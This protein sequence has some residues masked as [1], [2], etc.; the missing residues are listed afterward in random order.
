[1]FWCG[2]KSSR[3]AVVEMTCGMCNFT[4]NRMFILKLWQKRRW[5]VLSFRKYVQVDKCVITTKNKQYAQGG[6]S[7]DHA[8][9][10][11]SGSSQ[12]MDTHWVTLQS[13]THK[14]HTSQSMDTHWVTLQRKTHKQHTSQSM[15]T[16]W[17]TLQRKTHKQHTS[18][19]MDTHW[20][21][22]QS[23]THK[24]HTS[25]S[26]DTH[27]VTLQSKTHKQHTSQSMDTHWVT[28]QSKT[29]KQ[30]TSQSMDTHWV[31]LQSKTH[32]QHT[33]QSMDTHWVTLQ[34]KT[35]K[36]HFTINGHTLGDS[37]EQCTQTT[38]H[39]QWTHT[40]WLCRAIH[41][42]NTLHNRWTHTGWL[43]GAIHKKK[44]SHFTI[45]GHTLGDPAE[46]YTKTT[47]FTINRHTL[48][49]PAEWYTKY[50][51]VILQS[52]TQNNTDYAWVA[53]C[54]PN[55]FMMNTM[56]RVSICFTLSVLWMHIH[57]TIQC[58]ISNNWQPDASINKVSLNGAL[59]WSPVLLQV[60]VRENVARADQVPL[61]VLH[62]CTSCLKISTMLRASCI[63]MFCLQKNP[64]LLRR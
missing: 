8:D 60:T 41:T 27:W 33:S 48:G 42:N 39:N 58:A 38:L 22:L 44:T 7:G 19:S 63:L 2:G 37:A 28:L 10:Q 31:T 43:C 23:K 14:Q 20:V 49:H 32:K 18:Q 36:Q 25:Q 62:A 6:K 57:S 30:H 64:F 15:D 47:H 50:Y 61:R 53:S 55:T 17:V 16:H 34:S 9:Q 54:W 26:M 5:K 51:W 56:D 13:K 45:N 59:S 21:T 35:H 11:T 40:G 46:Q 52:E 4:D 12:S 29:H 3:C 24:Q 1:M